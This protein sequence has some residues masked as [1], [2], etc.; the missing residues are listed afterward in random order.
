MGRKS[1][2]KKQRKIKE[3]EGKNLEQKQLKESSPREEPRRDEV[4]NINYNFKVGYTV[5]VR[6]GVKDPDYGFD[7]GGW[8]G[9]I[10]DIEK[11]DNPLVHI[12]W[13]SETIRNMPDKLL[14]ACD[15]DNLDYNRM[16]LNES[17]ILLVRDPGW[18]KGLFATMTKEYYMLARLHYKMFDMKKIEKIFLKMKCMAF[19]SNQTRWVW[20]YEGE[21]KKLKF[22]GS[23]SDIPKE[24]R[25]IVLGSFFLRN[26]KEIYLNTNSFDRAIAAILFFDKYIPQKVARVTHITILNKIFDYLVEGK[27]PRHEEYFDNESPKYED[28]EKKMMELAEEL[29]EISNPV[30]RVSNAIE[31]LEELAKKPF[32]EVETLPIHYYEDGISGLR[33][34][35]NI[36][37]TVAL[38]H[39][40]GETDYTAHDIF[41]EVVK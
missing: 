9:E 2:E 8:Q 33:S 27:T 1:R 20:L 24:R 34:S 40:M 31:R 15:E 13:D 7:I 14:K 21:A 39:F 19:D 28:G 29:S 12:Q 6:K 35:L 32:D 30:Q 18:E 16:A 17:D 37:K 36:R 5:R 41:K 22:K 26:E 10:E 3:K 11:G 23:Y 25:P 4:I 38:R